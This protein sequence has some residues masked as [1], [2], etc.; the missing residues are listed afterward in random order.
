MKRILKL[1]FLLPVFLIGEILNHAGFLLDE[2]LFPSYRRIPVKD[3]VFIAG[4]P[5]SGTTFLHHLLAHDQEHF[6]TMKLWEILCAPSITQKYIFS[7]ICRMD[8]RMNKRF[9]RVLLRIDRRLFRDYAGVH[10]MSLLDVEEDDYL[11]FHVFSSVHLLFWFPSMKHLYKNLHFDQAYPSGKRRRKL[12]YYTACI[13]K[14]L[15]VFG[16]GR[17]YLSKSPM[18]TP[19]LGSLAQFFPDARF[20]YLV[21]YP[22]D[23]ISSNM[24]L[25]E[26]FS[27]VFATPVRMEQLRERVLNMA[28]HLYENALE[29]SAILGHA[30]V[31]LRFDHLTRHTVREIRKLYTR[32]GVPFREN[33]VLILEREMHAD[34]YRSTHHHSLEKYGLD[35]EELLI[36]YKT[37]YDEYFPGTGPET[38]PLQVPLVADR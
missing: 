8:M 35:M 7:W 18:H 36:R 10:P 3:P 1:A 24:S 16:R 27:R 14:H 21:R 22:H 4:M 13:R 28:D 12:R 37:I 17:I 2:I 5:R 26:M 19:R 34:K 11:F 6:T 20:I 33:Y 25:F 9:S 31:P 38:E 15:Y 30:M 32:L 29:K 23:V